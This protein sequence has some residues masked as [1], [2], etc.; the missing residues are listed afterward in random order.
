MSFLDL[1]ISIG[2]IGGICW[3]VSKTKLSDG[4]K[5]AIYFVAIVCVVGIVLAAL[6]LWDK[7]KSIQVP[8]L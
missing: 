8:H 7:A 3:G 4:F 6:G 2:L 1:V 5:K